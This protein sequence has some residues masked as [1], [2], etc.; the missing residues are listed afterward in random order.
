MKNE[1]ILIA[2]LKHR[3]VTRM[4]GFCLEDNEK[5]LTCEYL[6]NKS[7]ETFLF[8]ESKKY[9]LDW[10]LRFNII[11]VVAQGTYVKEFEADDMA[12]CYG[13]SK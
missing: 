10:R 12:V 9:V 11:T 1:A 3:N 13:N 8:D 5:I 6:P 7:L 2:K 4:L